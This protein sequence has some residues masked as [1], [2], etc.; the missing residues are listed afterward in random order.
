MLRLLG[1]LIFAC[2]WISGWIKYRLGIYVYIPEKY[3][4]P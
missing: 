2:G 3:R 4:R 1:K